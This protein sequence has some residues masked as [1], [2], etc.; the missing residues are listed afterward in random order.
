MGHGSR[1]CCVSTPHSGLTTAWSRPGIARFQGSTA[2]RFP[3]GR[4]ME[5]DNNNSFREALVCELRKQ[6]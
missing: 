6:F 2:N 5:R 4:P 3:R 1:K